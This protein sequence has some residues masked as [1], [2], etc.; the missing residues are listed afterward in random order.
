MVSKKANYLPENM[1]LGVQHMYVKRWFGMLGIALQKA[2]NF[3]A[4][5]DTGA[6]L[7]TTFCEPLPYVSDLM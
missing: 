5:T 4:I 1:R 3:Q 2:V 6:D 7:I